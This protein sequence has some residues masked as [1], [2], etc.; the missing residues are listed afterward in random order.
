MAFF[1]FKSWFTGIKGRLLLSGI[2]PV[3][4]FAFSSFLTAQSMGKLGNMLSEAYMTLTP[5]LTAIGKINEGR[6]SLSDGFHR[7]LAHTGSADLRLTDLKYAEENYGH[8]EAYFTNFENSSR[9]PGEEELYEPA[10]KVKDSYLS[11]SKEILALLKE[12]KPESDSKAKELM[13]GEW[14]KHSSTIDASMDALGAFYDEAAT[15]RLVEQDE[16]RSKAFNLLMLIGLTS[17]FLILASL[18]WTAF[19]VTRSVQKISSSLEDA[20]S[21]VADAITELSSTGQSL[22]QSSTAAAASLE[23]TVASLEE[24]TSMVQMNSDNAKQAAALSHSSR[25]A[26]ERGEKEIRELVS[27][28]QDIA[29]SSKKIEE[30]I[31]VIDD[32]AFQTNLLALNASVEAA[33]AGEHGKGFAVVAD[34]V[35]T[36]AQRS[37]TAAKDINGLI[38]DSV[39][40]IDRGTLTADKSGVVMNDI[41]I[42]VKKVSDLANEIAAASAEQT[43][44]IQQVS[45]AMNQ[46]DQGAQTNA[47]SSEQVAATAEE[48]SAQARHMKELVT[49]LNVVV[50]GMSSSEYST[51][52]PSSKKELAVKGPG[53]FSRF[54]FFAKKDTPSSETPKVHPV[55]K[56]EPKKPTL[57]AKAPV[58]AKKESKVIPLAKK[59]SPKTA[60]VKSVP[61]AQAKKVAS[62]DIIPFDDDDRGGIGDTSGF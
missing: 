61:V 21:Q 52:K 3:L 58:S 34:A 14:L 46:L 9:L 8:L 27:S 17:I 18:A 49:D 55:A 10:R 38:K 40:K 25:E 11:L 6:G 51:V 41:V 43:T 36:L 29:Q 30:I 26:A 47:A 24:M 42:S 50:T 57:A 12:S 35:R 45:K 13:N 56:T 16:Q 59:S 23:E 2:I 19:S 39:S 60:P 20:G 54:N 4:T 53:F 7:A 22:S 62:S 15:M 5:N 1:K 33:R 48:I 32:I 31:H 37:A 28:M 44:G